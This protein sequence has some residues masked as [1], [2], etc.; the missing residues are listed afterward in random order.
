[1]VPFSFPPLSSSPKLRSHRNGRILKIQPPEQNLLLHMQA[2]FR[3]PSLFLMFI[4]SIKLISLILYSPLPPPPLLPPGVYSSTPPPPPPP[5]VELRFRGAARARWREIGTEGSRK[6]EV[7]HEKEEIYF[8][9]R[10]CLWGKG[11]SPWLPEPG[12]ELSNGDIWSRKV[13][14]K[15]VP[16]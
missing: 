9:D 4:S 3:P 5:G 1:M 13:K 12:G 6:T 2:L 16:Y 10:F 8:D 11:E 7:E 15:I 14:E